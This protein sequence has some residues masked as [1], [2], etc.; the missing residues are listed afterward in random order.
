MSETQ[1]AELSGLID[2]ALEDLDD[3]EAVLRM[4]AIMCGQVRRGGQDAPDL[5]ARAQA[6]SER[7]SRPSRR[8]NRRSNRAENGSSRAERPRQNRQERRFAG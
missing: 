8:R 2:T 1:R 7:P 6:H 4:L 3:R 5:N